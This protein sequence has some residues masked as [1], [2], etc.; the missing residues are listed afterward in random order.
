LALQVAV[1]VPLLAVK[2]YGRPDVER[3][4]ARARALCRDVG[5][6]ME[7]YQALS[8]LFLF[9]LA[10]AELPVAAELAA[11]LLELGERAQDRFVCKWAHFFS[12]A[13]H[14]YVGE[15]GPALAHSEQ[16][17]ALYEPGP[18]REGYVHE[19]DPDISAR[20]Y[21]AMSLS[22]L[23][24]PDRA[25]QRMDEA[26]RLGRKG[27]SPWNLAFT[28][29][30]AAMFHHIRREPE[31]VLKRAEEAIEIAQKQGFPY[32]LGMG[33]VLRGWARA[34]A[35]EGGPALDEILQGVDYGATSGTRIGGSRMLGI[36][37]DARRSAGLLDEAVSTLEA[38]LAIST[39]TGSCF[40]EAE[41][42]RLRGETLLERDPGAEAVGEECFERAR[43]VAKAQHART[44]ELRATSSLARLRCRQGRGEEAVALLT[45][46]YDRF[47]E[48]FDT[49]DL[50][51]AR[52]LLVDLTRGVTPP[53][54]SA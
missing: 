3:S 44:L 16:A 40:W 18:Q 53:A 9:H 1:G 2:G 20:I 38:A 52:E 11:L 47:E 7:L 17:I 42:Q 10:R 30:F 31:L 8:G 27:A 12:G 36:I 21:A 41:L 34:G 4:Q 23:G 5:E 29:G 19:H 28:L 46:I 26:L 35:G 25:V 39:E 45:E 33:M 48:G 54:G 14:Y 49:P 37:G 6:G 15:F 51:E 43:A 32:W 24:Y 50:R 22:I 13:R